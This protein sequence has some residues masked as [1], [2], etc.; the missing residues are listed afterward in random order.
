MIYAQHPP[1]Q[2]LLMNRACREPWVEEDSGTKA[3]GPISNVGQ[4]HGEKE[5]TS[6]RMLVIPGIR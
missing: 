3:P 2:L 5:V 1:N 4:N 6:C